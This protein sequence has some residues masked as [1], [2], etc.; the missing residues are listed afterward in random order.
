M[1]ASPIMV[2]RLRIPD[3]FPGQRRAIVPQDIVR[4]CRRM[5]VVQDLH[6]LSIGSF[7]AAA[8]HYFQRR[9]GFSAAIVIHC[10]G[11]RGWC[12]LGSKKWLVDEGRAVFI[13]PGRP[14]AYGADAQAPWSINWMHFGGKRAQAYLDAL[15]IGPRQPLVN[16]PE[17]AVLIEAFEEIYGLLELGY[18]ESTLLAL[19]T[20]LGRFLAMFRTHGRAFY[21]KRRLA[22]EKIR[23]SMALMR[24]HLDKSFTLEALAA[25]VHMSVP[26]YC[27]LFKRQTNTSPILFLIRL[28]MQRACELLSGTDLPVREVA[29]GLGYRDPFYFSRVFKKTIGLPPGEYRR[30]VRV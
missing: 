29:R 14:H 16:L 25:D 5:P 15:G 23:K 17:S 27:S 4:Q 30:T 7:P 21:P 3:G 8:H 2:R 1:P 12:R 28:K 20:E 19:S 24:R 6:L 18:T 11:G 26:H 13:P 10:I 22:E 9:R